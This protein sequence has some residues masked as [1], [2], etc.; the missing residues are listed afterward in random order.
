MIRYCNVALKVPMKNSTFTYS[1]DSDEEILYRRV[2][3]PFGNRKKELVGFVLSVDDSIGECGYE[4][5]AIKRVLDDESVISKEQVVLAG[6]MAFLYKCSVGEALSLMVP[7]A[8]REVE[9]SP[10][11]MPSSFKR[12]ENL[13]P[14]QERALSEIREKRKDGKRVFY[15]YGVTGSGKS[16]VYM[17]LAEEEI[18]KGRQVLFLVPEITLSEQVSSEVYERFDKKV[19]IMHSSLTPSQRLK[20]HRAIRNGD[21]KFV[22]GA[23]SAVFAPFENLGLIILDEEHEQ[24]Y[25]SGNSPRYHARQIAQMRSEYNDAL[26]V[27]GSATPS[28]ESF[29]AMRKGRIEEIRMRNRIG[30]GAFP[31]VKVVNILSSRTLI[32]DALKTQMEREFKEGKGVILF[33]NRRGYSESLH[34]NT[35]GETFQCPN[36][37]VSLTYH[38]RRHRLECHICGYSEKLPEV[39]PN[40]SSHDIKSVG[41]GTEQIEDEVR[42]LF[43]FKKVCRLDSD[44]SGRDRKYIAKVLSDFKEGRIDILLGTQMIAKGL[45]F[46]LVSLVGVVNADISL[47]VPSFRANERTYELLKQVAGRV[48]RYR[49]DGKVIVQTSEVANRA[50]RAIELNE[51]EEFYYEELDARRA[52]NFPPY[53]RL[54]DY[55]LRSKVEEKARTGAFELERVLRAL[56]SKLEGVEVYPATS[57]LVERKNTYYRYHVLISSKEKAFSRLLVLLDE[58]EALYKVPSGAYLEIDVDP[59]DIS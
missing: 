36:C 31:I 42:R 10:L 56:T 22:I 4:I 45:N 27:M 5:K 18:E 59:V 34:C 38:K 29:E 46:P 50:I 25:K 8:R 37:S 21:V 24:S 17:R 1:F 49:P 57:C 47:H 26:L 6:R 55:T 3:V 58:V 53:S 52:L 30:D 48:G 20:A 2:I 43:P 13:S 51:D 15:I 7:N 32:S 39:C 14:D 16:E 40:C 54:V 23:R 9:S 35:C 33:L 19:A 41:F 11:F 28:F 44:A 12:I